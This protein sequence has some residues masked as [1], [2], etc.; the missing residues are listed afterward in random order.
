MGVPQPPTALIRGA[1]T[2]TICPVVIPPTFM[3]RVSISALIPDGERVVSS[4]PILH[5]TLFSS[6]S[7][8]M[9]AV[10]ASVTKSRYL[11]TSF[12]AAETPWPVPGGA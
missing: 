8:T 1:R 5:R 6:T 3:P 11:T 10:L 2:K 4:S 9:S 12:F 7:G